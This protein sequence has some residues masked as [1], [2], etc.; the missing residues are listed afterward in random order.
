MKY[1]GRVFGYWKEIISKVFLRG[2]FSK[3]EFCVEVEVFVK[4]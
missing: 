4:V 2:K 3:L 1:I